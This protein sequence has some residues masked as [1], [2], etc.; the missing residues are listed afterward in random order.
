MLQGAV[1]VGTSAFR[2]MFDAILTKPSG[3]V[4]QVLL[5][6]GSTMLVSWVRSDPKLKPGARVYL[7]EFGEWWLV[8]S[9]YATMDRAYIK[10]DWLVGG[11]TRHDR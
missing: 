3:R 10:T 4:T 2:H 6:K 8:E 5:T 1:R 9:V 7:K 11:N